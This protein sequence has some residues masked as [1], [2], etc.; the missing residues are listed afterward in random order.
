MPFLSMFLRARPSSNPPLATTKKG[1][2]EDSLFCSTEKCGVNTRHRGA[3]LRGARGPVDLGFATTEAERRP[4]PPLATTKRE[5]SWIPF[6][7]SS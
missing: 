4:N 5:S 3:V 6:F 2:Q 1:I 7:L